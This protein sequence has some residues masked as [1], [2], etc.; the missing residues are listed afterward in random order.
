MPFNTKKVI[1]VRKQ[2]LKERAVLKVLVRTCHKEASE[3]H[4]LHAV[5]HDDMFIHEV[6][7]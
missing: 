4:Q 3:S 2:S 7:H 5:V 6:V 1:N